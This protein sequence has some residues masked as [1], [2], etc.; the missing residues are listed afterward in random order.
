MVGLS[1]LYYLYTMFFESPLNDRVSK[2]ML[3]TFSL[4]KQ[5][6]ESDTRILSRTMYLVNNF[7]QLIYVLV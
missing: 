7:Q 1:L 6:T 2:Y 3:V 4:E 5:T